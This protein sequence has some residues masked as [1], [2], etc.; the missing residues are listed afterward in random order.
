MKRQGKQKMTEKERYET[1]VKNIAEN[2]EKLETSIAQQLFCQ[3]ENHSGIMG[4]AREAVWKSLFRQIV[5][6][7]YC[8]KQGVFIIDSYGH[9]SRE[10]DLAIFDEMYTPYIFKFGKLK[11]IPIEAVAAV[12]QCKSTTLNQGDLNE[13]VNSID[14]L[15]T[16]MCSVTR[17][18]AQLLDHNTMIKEAIEKL[19]EIK[20]GNV[21][22]S[23]G[24]GLSEENSWNKT[25][26]ATRPIKI[27]CALEPKTTGE[28]AK[29]TGENSE[30]FDIILTADEKR[31]HLLIPHRE[32]TLE[33]WNYSLNH[34]EQTLEHIPDEAERE[35]RKIIAKC[36]EEDKGRKE[37]SKGTPL[38]EE[39]CVTGRENAGEKIGPK[40]EE[41]NEPK[42]TDGEAGHSEHV[43]LSL[44]FQLN[45]LLMVI[46]NPMLF[47]HYAYARQ[48]QKIL[49]EMET[50]GNNLS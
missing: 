36:R 47:P 19:Q 38:L 26:T 1:A 42:E 9:V 16:S 34:A 32:Y 29:K 28:N 3:L 44:I 46:N 13:W 30:Q 21:K 7:K 41:G 5:P 33:E 4:S 43:I 17:T 31:L 25:Q 10:V 35:V 6:K 18:A 49:D 8:I 12:V 37:E 20:G 27:L 2:Y 45:Q 15:V 23:E 40:G 24:D 22:Q 48:F 11:F 39:L 14:A 50:G